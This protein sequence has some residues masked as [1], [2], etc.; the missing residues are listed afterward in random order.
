MRIAAPESAIA[1]S[2]W[3]DL[4]ETHRLMRSRKPR[5]PDPG[6][7]RFN[8]RFLDPRLRGDDDGYAEAPCG[9]DG[10]RHVTASS[11]SARHRRGLR[12]P[13]CA[14]EESL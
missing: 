1:P 12:S 11:C 5:R 2:D 3:C 13:A 6:S 10:L 8:Y 7:D 9:R 4:D 14:K